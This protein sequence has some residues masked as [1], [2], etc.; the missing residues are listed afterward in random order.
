[1]EAIT[2][3]ESVEPRAIQVMPVTWIAALASPSRGLVLAVVSTRTCSAL[4][5]MNR[6][7]GA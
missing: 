1:M 7:A 2:K 6:Y 4:S 5:S 3:L